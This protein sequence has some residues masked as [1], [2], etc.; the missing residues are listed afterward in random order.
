MRAP[1]TSGTGGLAPLLLLAAAAACNPPAS[2]PADDPPEVVIGERLFLE[3]RFA[4]FFAA[5]L[6]AGGVN[7][8]LAAGDP[9]LDTLE[10]TGDGR[11][12]GPFAGASMS[13]RACH[14]VDEAPDPDTTGIRTYADFARRSP[15]PDRGD[16]RTHTPRN[17]PP[18][19][20]AS[21]ARDEGSYLHFDGEFPS[22]EE[23][24]EGTF[25][26]RNFGW[27][28]AERADA[29]VHIA[30][31]IREDDGS[32]T[33]ALGC[34]GHSYTTILAGTAPGIPSACRLPE[35][36]RVDVTTATDAEVLHAVA[37]I[38]G[39]YMRGLV[40]QQDAAGRYVGAP[41]DRFLILNG[42][43]RLPD[44]G[45]S[46]LAYARRL[47]AALAALLA[48]KLLD[49][50]DVLSFEHHD[51]IFAFG[52][53]ELA[54]LRIF[55]AEPAGAAASMD[56]IAAGGVGNCIACHA[57]PH[58]SD[59]GFHNT[60]VA[61]EEYDGLHG[62]GAFVALAIP[63]L[64]E[65]HTAP[66]SFLPASALYPAGT[67]TFLSAP[68]AASPGR[69][70]LGV[71]NVLGNDAVPGAQPALVAT[72]GRLTGATTAAELLPLAVARFKTAG[73]RDLGQSAPYFHNGSAGGLEDAV[74]HYARA[75]A[76]ARGGT[77]RNGDGE[78][79]RIAIR[80]ADVAAL[81]AFLRALNEDYD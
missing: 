34:Y 67:G 78:L 33:L 40:Y 39:A 4:Q 72:L 3:T 62:A 61:Q 57:P 66:E 69:T 58:F 21:I 63:G 70:D 16:G 31:V 23:L 18:L 43:P 46:A 22:A 54:G 12:A 42:L 13:C 2:A 52:A 49:N 48:P 47:R 28:P 38:V 68:S 6:G 7:Q 30:R 81:A 17:S 65:R 10:T 55:L 53:D 35:A 14:L 77:V 75:S 56:E 36:L 8:R 73:L 44:A 37:A 32:D 20:N 51:Q 19:V 45:E 5:N 24:V 60:G 27:L 74:R 80:E 59:V 71:W 29:I 15:I 11:A 64:A 25:T 79:A 26:G 41:F 1:I 76:D 50:P 9:V